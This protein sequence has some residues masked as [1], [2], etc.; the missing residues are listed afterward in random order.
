[1]CSPKKGQIF[2]IIAQSRKKKQVIALL[3]NVFY[4]LKNCKVSQIVVEHLYSKD[5]QLT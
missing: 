5:R 3:Q 2:G 4:E 1:M